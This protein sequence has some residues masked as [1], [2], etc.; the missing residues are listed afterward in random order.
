[1]VPSICGIG[2]GSRDTNIGLWVKQ[3]KCSIKNGNEVTIK[4]EENHLMGLVH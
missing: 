1:M 3:K 4:E 2:L